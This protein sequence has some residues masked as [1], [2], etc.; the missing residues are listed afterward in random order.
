MSEKP[1]NTIFL[2]I[3]KTAGTSF[4][5][6]LERL[7]LPEERL[8]FPGQIPGMERLNALSDE[9]RADIRLVTGHFR[10]GLHQHLTGHSEYITFLR[11]PAERLISYYYYVKQNPKHR[12]YDLVANLSLYEFVT[13]IHRTDVRNAHI[14]MISGIKGEQKVMLENAIAHV[15]QYFSFVGI[16][17]YFQESLLLFQNEKQLPTS[18]LYYHVSNRTKNRPKVQELDSKTLTAIQEINAGD[19]IFYELMKKR[20]KEKYE[21]INNKK[22][23]ALSFNLSNRFNHC[24]NMG[25]QLIRT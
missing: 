23:K 9:E 16:V 1:K 22:L 18:T 24:I 13:T 19:Y 8:N 11:E 15:E 4:R 21:Q 20:F 7:Y 2:H 3:P 5:R 12:I 10:F 14:C 17:E 25:K 6:I